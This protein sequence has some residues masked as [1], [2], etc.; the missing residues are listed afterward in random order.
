MSLR[1]S[2]S[3]ASPS[4]GGAGPPGHDRLDH[5]AHRPGAALERVASARVQRGLR[6][7]ADRRIDLRADGGRRVRGGEDVAAA[8]VELVGEARRRR[9]RRARRLERAVDPLDAATDVRAPAGSTTTS[10]PGARCPPPPGRRS[11]VAAAPRGRMTHWTGRRKG[12]SWRSSATSTRLEMLEQRLPSYQSALAAPTTLSPC[13]AEMGMERILDVEPGGQSRISARSRGTRSSSQSTRS[14]LLTATTTWR[15]PSSAGQDA[16]RRDC[17]TMPL[18]A[19]M[20]TMAS[21]G[22][23]RAGDHVARVL[24]VPRACRR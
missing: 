11:G 14:I 2:A 5:R 1:A 13:S 7:P 15:M 20:S 19:S 17:S 8:D 16:W 18:R 3:G 22:G 6:D 24:R 21:V 9:S 10:S 23:R 12:P 4:R